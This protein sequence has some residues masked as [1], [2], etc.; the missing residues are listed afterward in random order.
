[1][2]IRLATGLALTGAF[3]A[4]TIAQTTVSMLPDRDNT[5]YEDNPTF[6]NGAGTSTFAGNNAGG[7]PR[8]ALMH[9]DIASNVPAG[10]VILS[11]SFGGR[12]L[13]SLST[14]NAPSSLHRATAA[15][16]EGT[17]LPP[18]NGGGG[19]AAT[20]GDAT[21]NHTY[22]PASFW[23]SPGGDFDPTPSGTF[24]M[25]TISFFTVPSQPGMVA[26]VQSWLDNPGQNFGWILR[27][28]ESSFGVA[29]RMTSRESAVSPP[30]LTVTY[31]APGQ[32][33]TIGTGCPVG[34]GNYSV[35]FVGAPVGGTT[36]QI[37][38]GNA[39]TPSIGV[40][41]FSLGL[42]TT[43]VPLLPGCTL[44]LP[45]AL[46]IIGGDAFVVSGGSAVANFN[47]PAGFPGYLVACQ[48][49]VLD[50]NPLGFSVS[51]AA[52]IVLQ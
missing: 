42:D 13:Q 45:L 27:S 50:N 20:V 30:T 43:G 10:S 33:A 41:F 51:N 5:I 11:A 12:I 34:A 22:F 3:C 19:T 44:Y 9:F 49:A 46:G 16:G 24:S 38:H 47:V 1:M 8:R 39:P 7:S 31:I 2:L 14:Q 32:S 35:A 36:I 21:W 25:P 26:D 40:T 29:R 4:S 18:G 15:W 48:G 6:S 23:T 37:T 52:A 28:D 17:S